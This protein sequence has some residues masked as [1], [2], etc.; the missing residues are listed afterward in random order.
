M[1]AAFIFTVNGVVYACA[2]DG[3]AHYA[4]N[5]AGGVGAGGAGGDNP[6]LVDVDGCLPR[7][8]FNLAARNW[9][10]AL[11]ALRPRFQRIKDE[12]RRCGGAT[13]VSR[14]EGGAEALALF[15]A[16]H[17]GEVPHGCAAR[18]CAQ[19]TGDELRLGDWEPL[20]R[21]TGALQSLLAQREAGRAAALRVHGETSIATAMVVNDMMRDARI[22]Y[23]D[24]VEH[25]ASAGDARITGMTC[26]DDVWN[27]FRGERAT[28]FTFDAGRIPVVYTRG[29][30]AVSAT[31]DF[32]DCRSAC[33]AGSAASGLT[34]DA[35]LT[36]LGAAEEWAHKTV[37]VHGRGEDAGTDLLWVQACCKQASMC[38]LRDS[39]R[40]IVVRLPVALRVPLV[41]TSDECSPLALHD[42]RAEFG[43]EVLRVADAGAGAAGEADVTY[44]VGRAFTP[45]ERSAMDRLLHEAC[46]EGEGEGEGGEGRTAKRSR[47]E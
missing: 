33:A 6:V 7:S 31:I 16:A 40:R 39:I 32:W 5:L 10:D 42:V 44:F 46:D 21:N 47:I 36:A 19:Q 18:A 14:E 4:F 22:E 27:C 29:E 11:L 20:L 35:L 3:D 41:C 45:E 37:R 1:P 24:V 12:V 30:G 34:T 15:F 2:R 9:A 43:G 13:F 28:T 8:D 38:D 17:G 26:S 23:T 25:A